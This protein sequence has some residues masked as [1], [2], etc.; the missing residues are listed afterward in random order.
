MENNGVIIGS[1]GLARPAWA[2]VNEMMQHY[3]DTE[4]GMPVRDERGIFER[5]SLEAFQAGLSWSTILR[6]RP[7]FREA[8][9][10]FDPEIVAAYTQKDVQ[11]LLDN[12]GIVRH[13]TKIEATINNAQ[14]TLSLRDG[15]GLADF[16]WSFQPATTPT[17]HT[18]DEV[19]TQSPESV[20]LASALRKDGFRFVGPTTMFALM[21]AVGII[22]THLMDSHRRATSGI[23]PQ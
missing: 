23:W 12:P 6:K 21:E 9:D 18:M 11:R 14:T 3:Y 2:T 16:V 22:D 7:A 5:L 20:A 1:G 15:G 4:R 10:F 8:F 17:P 13:R 19:P